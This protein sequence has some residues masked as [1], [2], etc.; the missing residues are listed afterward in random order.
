MSH[1]T[2]R[3]DRLRG[4]IQQEDFL[5]GQGLS[6]EVNIRLFCYPAEDEM[7]VRCFIR[8]CLADRTLRCRL[9]E[10]DLYRIFLDIC[11]EQGITDAIPAMEEQDGS[12]YL[13]EQL[14]YAADIQS[15]LAQIERRLRAAGPRREDDVLLID[16]VGDAYPF[17]R[18][19]TILEAV[20]PLFTGPILVMYPGTFNGQELRLFDRLPPNGYYRAFNLI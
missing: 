4:L 7:A 15:F 20:Q 10:C 9:I 6:N 12:A 17:V 16:G 2:E 14:R 11:E 19:H 5:R 13:L 3:L 8:Q 1:T 18:A